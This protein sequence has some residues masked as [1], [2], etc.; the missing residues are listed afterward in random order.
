MRRGLAG[1]PGSRHRGP[2]DSTGP[3]RLAGPPRRLR[4]APRAVRPEPAS[5]APREGAPALLSTPLRRWQSHRSCCWNRSWENLSTCV[6]ELMIAAG[7]RNPRLRYV[8]VIE[9]TPRGIPASTGVTHLPPAPTLSIVFAFIVMEE[10]HDL[11]AEDNRND[12]DDRNDRKDD[13]ALRDVTVHQAV[14]RIG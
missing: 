8:P 5:R 4:S 2:A 7:R 3:P 9:P 1:R 12:C 14:C 11:V 10:V 13:D 6:L